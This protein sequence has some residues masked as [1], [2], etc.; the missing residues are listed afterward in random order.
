MIH[1]DT[2]NLADAHAHSVPL[3]ADDGQPL[4]R[5]LM[6]SA[7]QVDVAAVPLAREKLPEGALFHAFN[8]T[9]IPQ[10]LE[11]IRV[12]TSVL[13]VGFPSRFS[14]RLASHAGRTARHH[15]LVVWSALS[16]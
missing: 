16:G 15:R 5:Q 9:H 7:G 6:D 11:Q 2:D 3:Y 10:P 12:G 8:H 14:R 4:W 13:V 1:V